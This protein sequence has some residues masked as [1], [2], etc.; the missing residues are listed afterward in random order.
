MTPA[1]YPSPQH[2][3]CALCAG[4]LGTVLA[5]CNRADCDIM[6]QLDAELDRACKLV[7]SV[8]AKASAPPARSRK[9]RQLRLF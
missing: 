8:N 1:A 3:H 9:P 5:G 4:D 6:R 2:L 7:R